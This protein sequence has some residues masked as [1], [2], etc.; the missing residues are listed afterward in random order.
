MD[1]DSTD[2]ANEIKSKVILHWN[3]RGL[4][5]FPEA[6]RIYGSHIEEIYLKWN[7][8]TTLPSWII[9]LSNVTNL[10]IYG[11]MI[12]EIPPELCQMNQLTVLDL[13]GNKLKQIP[14]YIG[15]LVS[16]KS[17]LI[18]ENCI[19]KLPIGKFSNATFMV[20]FNLILYVMFYR[21][22]RDA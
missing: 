14:P 9:E 17:F 12:K 6:I 19:D 8:L 1:S 11:N 13:S 3:C 18:N 22:E 16:L 10:Y 2:M 7:K 15:N 5:E 21:N 4:I 20:F